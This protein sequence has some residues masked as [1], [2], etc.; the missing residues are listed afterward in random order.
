MV[1]CHKGTGAEFVDLGEGKGHTPTEAVLPDFVADILTGHV[2]ENIV[3]GAAKPSEQNQA[4]HLKSQYPDQIQVADS[5][6][7][8]S[9]NTFIDNPAHDTGLDQIHQHFADHEYGG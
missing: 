2:N 6:I 5:A 7:V 3:E 9:Q 8:K 4:D 1:T